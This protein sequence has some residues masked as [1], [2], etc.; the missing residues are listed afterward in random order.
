MSKIAQEP[1]AEPIRVASSYGG[2]TDGSTWDE[3]RIFA[4]VCDS[5]WPV[6]LAKGD[7]QATSWYGV[8]CSLRKFAYRSSLKK[9]ALA[10]IGLSPLRRAVSVGR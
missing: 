4:C 10:T 1:H 2:A 6:G 7:T 5:L 3:D 9:L 8:D